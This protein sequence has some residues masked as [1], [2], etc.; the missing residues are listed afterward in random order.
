[1]SDSANSNIM[2]SSTA[3]AS[4]WCPPAGDM[5]HVTGQTHTT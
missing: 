1:M 4:Y 2:M 3:D 5:E